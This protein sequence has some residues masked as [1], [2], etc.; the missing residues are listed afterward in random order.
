MS[1]HETPGLYV[2]EVPQLP[3][4]IT[5][6]ETAIPGFVGYTA[7][8]TNAALDD[9][10]FKP[11][12]VRS[13]VDFVEFFGDSGA[14]GAVAHVSDSGGAPVVER[15]DPPS[16]HPL[17]FALQL[18]FDNGGRQCYVVSVGTRS[19]PGDGLPSIAALTQGIEALAQQDEVT[20]LVVP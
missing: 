11:T 19:G 18:Y 14:A 17:Y 15:V 20:L 16:Y 8:A 9:L 4:G 10:R 12:L 13:M 5:E 7:T 3:P 1:V 6:A 2:G